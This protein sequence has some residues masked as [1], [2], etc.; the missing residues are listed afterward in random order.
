[1]KKQKKPILSWVMILSILLLPFASCQ[2][3]DQNEA[4]VLPP[5]SSFVIDFSEFTDGAKSEALNGSYHHRNW[6]VINVAVWNTVI[7]VHLAVPVASFV[8]AFNHEPTQQADGSWLWLYQVAAGNNTYTAKL[9][10]KGEGINITWKMYISKT[11]LGAFSDF[12][13][14]EGISNI[15]GTQGDWTLY[16]S[17]TENYPFVGIE[18]YKNFDGTFGTTYTNIVPGGSENGGYIS[19]EFTKETPYNAFYDIYNKGQNNLTEIQ[20]HTVNKNGRIKDPKHFGT[21]NFYCWDSTGADI[22]CP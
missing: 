5:E 1:M 13:W 16:K 21:N 8:E 20:W 17:P 10:G 6:A 9:F 4:P 19:Y 7:A 3:D 2:K 14:Y 22:V 12:L 15:A 11:G 18:W